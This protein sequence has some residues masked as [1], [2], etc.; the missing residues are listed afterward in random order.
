[1]ESWAALVSFEYDRRLENS[2][3]AI[4]ECQIAQSRLTDFGMRPGPSVSAH[5]FGHDSRSGHRFSD[6]IPVSNFFKKLKDNINDS[7]SYLSF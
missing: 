1:M 2:D 7:A 5:N 4:A 6:L 3:F